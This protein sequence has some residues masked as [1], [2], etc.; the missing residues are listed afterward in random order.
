MLKKIVSFL[1]ALC[2]AAELTAF[3]IPYD[4]YMA[5]RHEYTSATYKISPGL[6]Y[7]EYLTDNEKYGYERSFVYE[8]TPMQG[9][10]FVPS[11]GHYVY[12]TTSLGTITKELEKDGVRVVGGINGDFYSTA[13]GVPIG[14]MIIDREI[15]SSDNDRTAMGFDSEGKAFISKP[16][17][18]ALLSDGE[19]DITL[20]HINKYPLEYSLYLLTDRFYPTTKTTL[21]STEIVL[22]PYTEVVVYETEEEYKKAIELPDEMTEPSEKTEDIESTEDIEQPEDIEQ[23]EETEQTEDAEQTEVTENTENTEKTEP[24]KEPVYFWL[25]ASDEIKQEDSD[26]TPEEVDSEKENETSEDEKDGTSE[27]TTTEESENDDETSSENTENLQ[28]DTDNPEACDKSDEENPDEDIPDEDIPEDE[29]PEEKS[30]YAKRYT[31]SDEKLTIG[32]SIKVVAI[33]IRLDS[34]NSEIPAG[35]FVIC[36]ENENQSSKVAHIEKADEFELSVS[37]NE[38]WYGAVHAIGNAGGLILKDGEYCDDV[39][40]DHYPYAHPRTA[41]GITADGKVIFYCVDGRQ[42]SS[43][44]LRIDQLSHEMK[45]LGCVIAM[46]LDGGGSTTAYAA[47]PGESFSTLKNSPSGIVE[48]KTANSLVFINTTERVG[49]A[50]RFTFYPERPYVVC[51]GS[52][53]LLPKPFA[54]DT[55]FH[56]VDLPDDFNY[57]YYTSPIQTDSRVVDGNRFVSG[58]KCG[59]VKVYVHV[60]QDGNTLEYMAGTVFVLSDISDFSFDTQEAE[61]YPFEPLKLSFTAGYHTAPLFYDKNS[62][63]FSLANA[64]EEKAEDKEGENTDLPDDSLPENDADAV[65]ELPEDETAEAQEPKEKEFFKIPEDE[66]LSNEKGNITK[67]LVFTPTTQNETIVFSAK[68]GNLVRDIT[69]HVK[70]FPFVD[71][72]SHWSAKNLV[73]IYKLNLMQGEF[74]GEELAFVPQRNMTK[75]EFITVLARMLYPDI[76]KEASAD[77]AEDVTELAEGTEVTQPPSP[78]TETEETDSEPA[79]ENNTEVE[80]ESVTEIEAETETETEEETDTTETSEETDSSQ[81]VE[82]ENGERETVEITYPFA[83]FADIPAWAQ[84]YYAAMNESGLLELLAKNDESGQARIYPTEYITRYDVLVMLGALCE[85]TNEELL[86]AYA[87]SYIFDASPHKQLIN[88]AVKAGIFEGYEDNTLRPANLLTRAEAATVI[89]RFYNK[90]F[91]TISE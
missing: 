65:Q 54:T 52:E 77:K 23:I 76:D 67:D 1:V 39:E 33:D 51:G 69:V 14:G 32:C 35:C 9:T 44:G 79:T 80:T 48:R 26:I 70:K 68:L 34:V 30:F 5:G 64:V 4:T 60:E 28:E 2:C 43:G 17:I 86:D 82:T 47:L 38:E 42:K 27:E 81:S 11:S 37:A 61:L 13:T 62:L 12:G 91:L 55:N 78:E 50:S 16:E 22:M 87:D 59:P 45:E 53:Y 49:G 21:A 73:E 57:T 58:E 40:I 8:Y 84:K 46:N 75:S 88:N 85:S 63:R 74:L 24:E 25:F 31:V 41:A 20:E 71:S 83:D 19:N 56:P 18:R 6:T 66:S 10:S 72:F 29:I 36:A 7:T 90:E 89:L 3:A 15:Y